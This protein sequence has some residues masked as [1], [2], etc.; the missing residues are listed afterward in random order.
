MSIFTFD[1]SKNLRKERNEDVLDRLKKGDALSSF[2]SYASWYP[3]RPI[4]KKDPKALGKLYGSKPIN[5]MPVQKA[6][7]TELK[8]LSNPFRLV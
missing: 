5:D 1:R 6:A 2:D 3:P 8:E 7:R 4:I